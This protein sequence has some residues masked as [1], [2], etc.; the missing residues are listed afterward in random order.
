[1]PLDPALQYWIARSQQTFG[2]YSP[3]EVEQYL[4][5]GNILPTDYFRSE[6]DTEWTTVAQALGIA[7]PPP[8]AAGAA[9]H[10][11]GA[12]D[13]EG[14]ARSMAVT[15][16]ILAGVGFLCCGLFVSIP[17]IVIAAIAMKRPPASARPLAIWG[18]V[19]NI[20]VTII[21][22]A[23]IFI[24]PIIM[25]AILGGMTPNGRGGL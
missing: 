7:L 14:P 23:L 5:S 6:T 10:F 4:R 11:G 22:I 15:S 13:S 3:A 16:L 25:Q 21:S 20:I 17:G 9:G 8:T 2:P 12:S 1:M 24:G 18:L 19:A